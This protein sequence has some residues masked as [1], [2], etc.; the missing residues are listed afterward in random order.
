MSGTTNKGGSSGKSRRI[1]TCPNHH[2]KRGK[3]CITKALNA[4]YIEKAVK[5]TITD[6]INKYLSTSPL[7][8]AVFD[9]RLSAIKEEVGVLEEQKH[10]QIETDRQD[11]PEFRLFRSAF[12]VLADGEAREVGHRDREEHHQDVGRLSEAV[13]DQAQQK[14]SQIPPLQRHDIVDQKG[15]GKEPEEEYGGGK[16]HR[17]NP[18]VESGKFGFI[19]GFCLCTFLSVAKEKY[20]KNRHLRESPTVPPLRNPP[21]DLRDSFARGERV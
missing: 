5:L 1:Y 4:E 12:T 3:K 9:K 6:S 20:Q 15:E 21:P 16:D 8:S 10:G 13:E 14:Q 17:E 11:Q 19:E 18:F 2:S 7:S